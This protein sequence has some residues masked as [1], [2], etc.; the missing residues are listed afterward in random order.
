MTRTE[1]LL[2]DLI[3]LPSVNPAF[4]PAADPRAGE[5][6]VGEF[7]A[8]VAAAG[9]LE[10]EFQE[11]LPGRSNLLARLVPT[12]KVRQRILLA[13]HMDTV[14]VTSDDQFDPRFQQGRIYGRGACD[15]KGSIAVYLTALLELA[16]SKTRPQSTEIVLAAL[17]DEENGQSGSRHLA[18]SRF[19]AD[20]AIVGEPTLLSVVT[21][22]KGDLWLQL[23]TRGKA[24]HG[25][26]PELGR[27]A[28]HQMAKIVDLLETDYAW[29]L[30][31]RPHP[32]LCHPTINVGTIAGGRQ[33]NIVPDQCVIRIDRRTIPGENDA[34]VKREILAFLR[35][36]GT[37]ARLID[38]KTNEPAPP[39]ETDIHLPLVRQLL[40]A[41]GQSKPAGVDFFTDA[42]VLTSAGI[43]C[44]VFGPG[45]IAQAHTNDEWVSTRQLETGTRI[46][47][48]FFDTLP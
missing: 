35:E 36:R 8:S 38:T 16:A 48:R 40:Q 42:G 22:H 11:V 43:P 18:R 2:R 4:V 13:P 14:G 33:P 7:L 47:R 26:R 21:A 29:Q 27:N 41:A 20:L 9:G 46:L 39:M 19:K 34:A 17:I 12:G 23:E 44:V 37:P 5:R 6:G 15:T 31:R 28:I 30:R 25:S 3:A 32:L 1:Q 10:V 24:A 45:D